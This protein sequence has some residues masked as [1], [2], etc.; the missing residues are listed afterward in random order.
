V[1]VTFFGNVANG[2]EVYGAGELS[3]VVG[4]WASAE[5]VFAAREPFP[6]KSIGASLVFGK[7]PALMGENDVMFSEGIARASHSLIKYATLF[8]EV[9]L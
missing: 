1:T 4:K 6:G 3:S 9:K 7:I 5:L 8:M 2:Q